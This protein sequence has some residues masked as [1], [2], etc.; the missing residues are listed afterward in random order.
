MNQLWENLGKILSPCPESKWMATHTGAT[1][2]LKVW[3]SVFDL[4]VTGRDDH[5]RSLIGRVRIDLLNPGRILEMTK[6]PVL[7]LGNMGAFDEN[8]VSYPWIVSTDNHVRM[9]YVG[10]MPT[11]I[12]PFQVHVGLAL[13]K[14][15]DQFHRYSRAPIS[16]RTNEDYLGMGSVCVL[17]ENDAWKMWYTS[18]TAWEKHENK[19]RHRY[20]IKYVES[21]DGIYWR[22]RN[23][24]CINFQNDEEIAICRPSVLKAKDMYH[25]MWYCYRGDHYKIG[26]AAS[27]DGIHWERKDDEMVLPSSGTRWDSESQAYPHVFRFRDHL[28][29]LYCGNGYGKEGLGLARTPVWF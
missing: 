5:N 12:T 11:I 3:D 8:G 21:N 1:F 18:F 23:S 29:L 2:A 17:K 9:Y 25:H 26:Y 6:G 27:N 22:R 19:L 28:Y 10:W 15:K 24:I 4:Y 13:M 16:T 20:L 7:I 14:T